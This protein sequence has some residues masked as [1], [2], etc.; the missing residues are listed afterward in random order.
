MLRLPQQSN[1]RHTKYIKIT[2]MKILD[3]YKKQREDKEKHEKEVMTCPQCGKR[4]LDQTFMSGSR[5]AGEAHCMT[6]GCS[7]RI[8]F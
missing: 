4:L 1:R 5:M 8:I 6:V 7:F 3:S 2:N